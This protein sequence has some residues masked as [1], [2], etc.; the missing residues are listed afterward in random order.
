MATLVRTTQINQLFVGFLWVMFAV[1]LGI[2]TASQNLELVILGITIIAGV[3]GALVS[4]IVMLLA[5]LV[6]SP[7]RTLIATEAS[8]PLPLDIGQLLVLAFIGVWFMVRIAKKQRPLTLIWT[9]I[10]LFLLIF[11]FA[12]GLSVFAATSLGAW[13]SEWL[14]WII[15]LFIV[16]LAMDM[17]R[18]LHWHWFVFGLILAATANAVVGVYIFFG[19]SGADHLAINQF[20]FRAFGTF[21]QPNPF[22]G[23]MGLMIPIGIAM[24]ASYGMQT[25]QQ[26]RRNN[27]L[28]FGSILRLSFYAGASLLMMAGIIV[29][30]S[31][32][33]WLSLVI[34][35]AVMAFALPKK[36]WQ[37]VVLL[38]L[39]VVV[40]SG[41]WLSGLLP[42]SVIDRVSSSTQEFLTI[43]D[44]RGVDITIEN[45]AVVERLAHWQAAGDMAQDHPWIGVGFGN[46]EVAYEQYR[47]INWDEALGHAHNYYLNILAETGIIGGLGYVVMWAMLLIYTWRV[48]LHPDGTVRLIA[49]GLLGTW[50]YLLMHSMLDNLYV[51]NLFLHI[52][53][54]IGLVAILHRQSHQM[55]QVK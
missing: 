54:M 30:W 15:I 35:F 50:S 44:V 24:A 17:S 9:P 39:V 2:V 1:L 40:V 18:S 33:A 4:P 20:Q 28:S 5:M 27:T 6:L 10:Y 29:S 12:S 26:L 21:G 36:L 23:F 8:F 51:N 25:W 22:G 42:Q 43:S 47:L 38:I 52:G 53:V 19:G 11:I 46:Y 31:R 45:F 13:L 34:A 41:L 32:G 14:K 49:I 48:R 7:L 37:S 55:I 3:V 16:V